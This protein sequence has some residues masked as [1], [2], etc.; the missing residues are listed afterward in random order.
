MKHSYVI[1]PSRRRSGF[2]RNDSA[3]NNPES[4]PQMVR[5]QALAF[6]FSRSLAIALA[7]L[8][9][10]RCGFAQTAAPAQSPFD[11]NLDKGAQSYLD[12]RAAAVE[13]IQTTA[14]A[15]ARANTF[16]AFVLDAIGG[17]PKERAP[18]NATV[19]GTLDEDGF[20]VQRVIYDSLPGFHV[21]A[22]LYLP[23]SGR[24][25]FP[26]ILYTPGHYPAGK[27]EAWALAAN[28]ARNGI[29]VLAYDPIGEGERL[30]YFDPET[31]KSLAGAPTGEHSEAGVQISL[32]GDHIARYFV[33]DAM[34]GIDYLAGRSD[35]DA[36]RIGALGCSG[37]GTVTAYLAAL[38]RR[39]K[40]A[41]V[42]CY[43]TSFSALL[44]TI[45]PQEAEQTIPGFIAHGFDFPDWIEA[46][47]PIPYAVISTT[48]DMIPFEGTRKSV[49]EA[50]RIYGIYGA[51]NNLQWITGPG[52]HGNLR[53]I[54]P[55]IIRFFIQR[56][57][58]STEAP[59]LVQLDASPAAQLQCTVAGQV[60]TSLHDETLFSLNRAESRDLPGK[61][62]PI[63]SP[64][65]L[66]KFRNRLVHD[67]RIL[68]GAEVNPGASAL[69]VSLA[70]SSQRNGYEVQ[71]VKFPSVTGEELSGL[72]ALPTRPGKG[73]AV[74]LLDQSGNDDISREGGELDRLA[75][76]GSIVFVPQLPPAVP[77]RGAPK[78][79]LLGPYY[80]A[81]LRAE[82]VAKTLVGLR[83]DDAIR[84]VDW[85]SSRPDV[86]PAAI[87]ARASGAMGIVLLHAAAL[88][89]RIREV[90]VDR[91]LLSYKDAV[92]SPVTRNLA[93][94]V[95]PGVL[96]YYDLPGLVVGISPRPVSIVSP[97]NGEGNPVA[98]DQAQQALA[99]V[100]A[101]DR[102]LHRAG[103]VNLTT[104][105]HDLSSTKAAQG[106]A[107]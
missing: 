5:S 77:D 4:T 87:S 86:N 46:A 41:G 84:C 12:R 18:L 31:K 95:L 13:R 69:Q 102:A 64:S 24:A 59:N 6:R 30:Q 23:K 45:G 17:L 89:P 47:A 48:E 75:S 11:A 49:D 39:V 99:W 76:S 44:G 22:N 53:P 104:P 21:T 55:E 35:I 82:L 79:E 52:R 25:P 101:S 96:H 88:D 94:S 90:T 80:I 15:E 14:D 16:R 34:R 70:G 85:L 50:K 3:R 38:D 32:A 71:D 54:H 8:G 42:A 1:V 66:N 63:R 20:E 97:I 33:W 72:L 29:A 93:Q 105:R 74:L 9:F 56:L 61:P 103:R 40:A 98:A 19:A 10:L 58:Q 37:G 60:S 28:L 81:S 68:T 100:F 43:I 83:I 26:A 57:A 7:C 92:E 67:I 27:Y 51:S 107:K 78:S 73:P 106:S 91:T 36:N 62:P 2:G 65:D